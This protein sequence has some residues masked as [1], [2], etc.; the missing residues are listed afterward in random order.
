MHI[1]RGQRFRSVK[2]HCWLLSGLEHGGSLSSC[3]WQMLR[4]VAA[5]PPVYLRR[6]IIAII[7]FH[8]AKHHPQ[9]FTLLA[10]SVPW[11]PFYAVVS[12]IVPM[13]TDVETEEGRSRNCINKVMWLVSSRAW[14]HLPALPR[15]LSTLRSV[16]VPFLCASVLSTCYVQGRFPPNMLMNVRQD[17]PPG[18]GDGRSWSHEES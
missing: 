15:R 3:I 10:H 4:S 18:S 1:E 14:L 7:N 6:I 5:I 12:I 8:E 11:Q 2:L 16:L 17:G 9:G 13:V